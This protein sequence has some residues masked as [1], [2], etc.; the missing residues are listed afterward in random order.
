MLHQKARGRAKW[1]RARKHAHST[2]TCTYTHPLALTHTHA[3]SHAPLHPA[4]APPAPALSRSPAK[5]STA[6]E[7]CL[8]TEGKLPLCSDWLSSL[9]TA[10]A[11]PASQARCERHTDPMKQIIQ[12]RGQA[13][14]PGNSQEKKSGRRWRE[15]RKALCDWL[16][17][18]L[19]VLIGL[20]L[21]SL[22]SFIHF[23]ACLST[24]C[25]VSST[26]SQF[27]QLP[28]WPPCPQ[29]NPLPKVK[30]KTALLKWDWFRQAGAEQDPSNK[31]T[32]SCQHGIKKLVI[33][34]L[35]KQHKCSSCCRCWWACYCVACNGHGPVKGVISFSFNNA[36]FDRAVLRARCKTRISKWLVCFE[37]LCFWRQP[38]RGLQS[39]FKHSKLLAPVVWGINVNTPQDQE[40]TL[41]S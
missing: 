22:Q 36:A 18:F 24:S 1:T 35:L 38:G 30:A 16:T 37:K 32:S 3:Q 9:A 33:N 29:G 25:S 15:R 13:Q 4:A 40:F 10:Y 6:R 41:N 27:V 17:D 23:S 8:E 31:S 34:N 21:S 19:F 11:Q 26:L 5:T 12:R 28:E 39:L 7:T 14:W 2:C 20:M